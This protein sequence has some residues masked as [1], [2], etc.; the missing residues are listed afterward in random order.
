MAVALNELRRGRAPGA[1]ICASATA[2]S[3]PPASRAG[4]IDCKDAEERR[5]SRSAW[6]APDLTNIQYRRA[7]DVFN[8]A[9]AGQGRRAGQALRGVRPRCSCRP[10][11]NEPTT[12]RRRSR[13]RR[14]RI[15]LERTSRFES[16]AACTQRIIDEVGPRKG[17]DDEGAS[18]ARRD[19]RQRVLPPRLQREPLLRLRP[20]GRELP[21]AGGHRRASSQVDR[22]GHGRAARRCADQRGQDPRVPAAVR[23]RR[24]VLP[25]RRREASR[26]RPRRWPRVSRRR[27]GVQAAEVDDTRSPR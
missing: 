17:E 26:I 18:V 24:R 20:R 23:A 15:A 27:D 22:S 21:H 11:T 3:P 16:A 25:A 10:S 13:S 7:V 9:E 4:D 2:R 19:P 6:P 14:P 8:K 12:R 1:A 5:P